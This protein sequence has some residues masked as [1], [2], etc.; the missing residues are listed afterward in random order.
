MNTL[1][2]LAILWDIAKQREEE[3]KIERIKIEEQILAM[4]PAKEEGSE[5]VTTDHGAKIQLTGKLAYKA[6][7]D[8][9][10]EITKTWPEEVRPLKLE[11]K[12]DETKLKAIRAQSPKAW[13]QIAQAVTV[14]PAKTGVSIKFTK[15]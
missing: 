5:T 10:F 11:T 14:T 7:M 13:A 15:E 1:D 4:H 6:D 2:Q 12:L 3:A 8:K 9:L